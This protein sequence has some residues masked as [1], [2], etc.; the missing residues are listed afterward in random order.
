MVPG[1]F[2]Q[3]MKTKTTIRSSKCRVHP[4]CRNSIRVPRIIKVSTMVFYS[5]GHCE[6][7]VAF[8][9]PAFTAYRVLHPD[10]YSGQVDI[11]VRGFSEPLRWFRVLQCTVLISTQRFCGRGPGGSAAPNTNVA[12]CP[13]H[14]HKFSV[15]LPADVLFK[16]CHS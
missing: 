16:S 9:I 4:I 1:S 2:R 12:P 14:Q 10:L 7:I 11:R 5:A 6:L 13:R 15:A 3:V 8:S